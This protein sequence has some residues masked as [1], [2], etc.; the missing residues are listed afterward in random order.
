MNKPAKKVNVK[1]DGIFC[2]YDQLTIISGKCPEQKIPSKEIT[3]FLTEKTPKQVAEGAVR[4]YKDGDKYNIVSGHFKALE[5]LY[6]GIEAIDAVVVNKG[7]ALRCIAPHPGKKK[8]TNAEVT[9]N[10]QETKKPLSKEELLASPLF[11][12]NKFKASETKQV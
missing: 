1:V 7:M 4:V 3:L 9:E 10:I 11:K 6:T 12:S 5:Q 2:V 8:E